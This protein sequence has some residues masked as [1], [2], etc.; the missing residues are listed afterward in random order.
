VLALAAIVILATKLLIQRHKNTTTSTP[1]PPG[2]K[3]LLFIGNAL[4]F[5]KSDACREYV[6]WGIRYNSPLRFLP[7]CQPLILQRSTGDILHATAF[8][9][10][11]IVLNSRK[12]ADDLFENRANIY[13]DRPAS[14]VVGL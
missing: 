14:H 4:D 9:T 3:P 11:V 1:Y 6:N 5:P 8:G 2:P 12:M 10:H 7:T 13:S